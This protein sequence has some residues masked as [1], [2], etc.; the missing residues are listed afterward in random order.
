MTIKDDPWE[1]MK[2]PTLKLF[3]LRLFGEHDFVEET[4]KK[5]DRIN[6]IAKQDFLDRRPRPPILWPSI[7]S[8]DWPRPPKRPSIYKY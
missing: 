7:N 6:A 4:K 3:V 8:V 2:Y 5:I 1:T